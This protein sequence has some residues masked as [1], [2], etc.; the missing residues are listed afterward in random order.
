MPQ[1]PKHLPS[2][3]GRRGH[4]AV[5]DQPGLR[6]WIRDRVLLNPRMTLDE[7]FAEVSQTTFK[8]GRTALSEYRAQVLRKQQEIALAAVQSS[9]ILDLLR[10]LRTDV[11]D[12]KAI[13]MAERDAVVTRNREAAT[14]VTKRQHGPKNVR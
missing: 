2:P 9:E 7:L 3:R 11:A 12:L 14:P 5:N 8:I 4:S 13:F 10:E 6:E 1:P